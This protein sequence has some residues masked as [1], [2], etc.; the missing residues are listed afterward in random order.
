MSLISCPDC[1]SRVSD[2]TLHCPTCGRPI[3]AAAQARRNTQVLIVL[4][5]LLALWL[6]KTFYL[7][8]RQDERM[9]QETLA[10]EHEYISVLLSGVRRQAG[11][12]KAM[13]DSGWVFRGNPTL[14]NRLEDYG[15]AALSRLVDCVDDT[16]PAN[17]TADGQPV[18]FG[19]LCVTALARFVDLGDSTLPVDWP[20]RVEATASAIEL[21]RAKAAWQEVV[22]DGSYRL[23]DNHP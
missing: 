21:R 16:A 12:F 11:Y 10:T 9:R 6:F 18:A 17:T 4:L 1:G 7:D 3:A 5:I 19:V 13:P 23:R 8:P 2:S 20:G 22:A 14:M 15:E